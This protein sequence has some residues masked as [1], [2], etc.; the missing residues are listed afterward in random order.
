M[1]FFLVEDNPN[2]DNEAKLSI[3]SENFDEQLSPSCV[4]FD[5]TVSDVHSNHGKE[6]EFDDEDE[7]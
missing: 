2:L 4:E 7:M 3:Q 1:I 5:D 6:K